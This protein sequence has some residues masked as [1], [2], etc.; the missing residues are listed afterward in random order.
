MDCLHSFAMDSKPEDAVSHYGD[1]DNKKD[2]EVD[3]S[4]EMKIDVADTDLA[5]PLGAAKSQTHGAAVLHSCGLSPADALEKAGA[6]YGW[7]YSHH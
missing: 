7:I 6:I 1:A 3:G 2:L 5:A 4:A